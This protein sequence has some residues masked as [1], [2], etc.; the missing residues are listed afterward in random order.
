VALESI[1]LQTRHIIAVLNSRGHSISSIYMSGGQSKN[2]ILMQLFA[3]VCDMPVVLPQDHAAAVV[4]GAAILGRFAAEGG[5]KGDQVDQAKAL[6]NVMVEMTPPGTLI[7]P[8]ASVKDRK[9]L[10]A[11][12]KIFMETI[13]IQRRWRVEMEEAAC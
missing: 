6:W 1:A 5:G 12:F 9:L 10:N 7:V 11:K 3:D 13:D 2:L 8:S 4:R